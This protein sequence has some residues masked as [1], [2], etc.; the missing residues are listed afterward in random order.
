MIRDTF[1]TNPGLSELFKRKI[2]ERARFVGLSEGLIDFE[3]Q[4]DKKGTYQ[5]NLRTFY[6]EYPQ[7]TQNS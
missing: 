3:A 6:R 7:L 1:E 5:D 2:I 4:I